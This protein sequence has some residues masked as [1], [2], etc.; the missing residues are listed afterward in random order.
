MITKADK[1]NAVAIFNK[2]TY[3]IKIKVI[4]DSQKFQKIG[5]VDENDNTTRIK[6]SIQSRLLAL[7]KENMLTKLVYEHF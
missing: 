6:G 2:S 4:L 7:T 1:S 5:P 3:L